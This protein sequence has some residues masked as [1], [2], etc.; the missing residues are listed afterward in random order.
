MLVLALESSTA[1]GGVALIRDGH[2][3]AQ[4]SSLR[5][6]SHAEFMNPALAK[7]IQSQNLTLADVDLIAVSR[8]PGS[9]TG[10]RV[11]GN[12]AKALAYALGKKIWIVDSL[13]V[14][15][16]QIHWTEPTLVGLNA[17]KNMIYASLYQDRTRM[18][19]PVA[20]PLATLSESLKSQFASTDITYVGDAF[21]LVADTNGIRLSMASG[22]SDYPTAA[23][24]GNLYFQNPNVGQTIS[25]DQF[26][27][28]YL[29]ESEAEENL[30]L[31]SVK[32]S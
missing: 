29:R 6:R 14:L 32:N 27:P 13:S 23:L 30:R 3:L 19:G 2:V 24:L 21:S 11:A 26:L 5:Q 8:G 1:L 10:I 12:M 18:V 22:A 17:F 15:A 25:W 4:E 9:F 7:V 16:S 28:L 31:K 20:L